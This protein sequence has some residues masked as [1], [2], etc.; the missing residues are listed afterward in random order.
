[1]NGTEMPNMKQGQNQKIYQK[2]LGGLLGNFIRTIQLCSFNF[3]FKEQQQKFQ[4][5]LF[6]HTFTVDLFKPLLDHLILM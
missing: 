3:K 1:M 6:L 2:S 4:Q 5:C